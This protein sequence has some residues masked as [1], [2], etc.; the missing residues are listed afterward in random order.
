[1]STSAREESK[2]D[3][4]LSIKLATAIKGKLNITKKTFLFFKQE[5]LKYK[6]M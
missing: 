1:V 6:H 2:T 3:I 4:H 5:Q